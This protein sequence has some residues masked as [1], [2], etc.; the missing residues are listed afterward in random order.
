MCGGWWRQGAAERMTASECVFGPPHM[1]SLCSDQCQ[2]GLGSRPVV[3]VPELVATP[4]KV[5]MQACRHR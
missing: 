1:L 4:C 5:Q 2:A 3:A